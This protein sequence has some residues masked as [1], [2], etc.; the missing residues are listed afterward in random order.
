MGVNFGFLTLF[1]NDN[2]GLGTDSDFI[3]LRKNKEYRN[4]YKSQKTNG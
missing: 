4:S 2:A 1:S 3:G